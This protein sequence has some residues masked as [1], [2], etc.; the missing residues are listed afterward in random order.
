[1]A[2]V[3][4]VTILELSHPPQE[5]NSYPSLQTPEWLLFLLAAQTQFI[6]NQ[7]TP[8]RTRHPQLLVRPRPPLTPTATTTAEPPTPSHAPPLLQRPEC[9][10]PLLPR[11]IPR[12]KVARRAVLV[13]PDQH[14]RNAVR[15]VGLE[16]E[17]QQDQDK[18]DEDAKGD[19]EEE[20]GFFGAWRWF[21]RV[22]HVAVSQGEGWG[23]GAGGEEG[24]G[25]VREGRWWWW[26]W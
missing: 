20:D 25:G 4:V 6:Q 14:L 1:M 18:H 8:P 23:W 10:P 19:E 24:W 15:Q 21:G 3:R 5:I 2:G 17:Q 12:A 11:P 7:T 13:V 16:G 22:R 26:W 9:L